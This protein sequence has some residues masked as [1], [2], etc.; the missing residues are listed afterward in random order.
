MPARSHGQSRTVLYNVWKAIRGRC[1]NPNYS[2]F[3]HYGGRGITVCEEWSNYENFHAWAMGHGWKPGLHVDRFPDQNGPY[4]PDNCRIA[5]RSQNHRNTRVNRIIE[6]FGEKK[7][8]AE[9]IDDP[10]CVVN[11]MTLFNRVHTHGWPAE[12]AITTAAMGPDR[13]ARWRQ[14]QGVV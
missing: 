3:Q 5:T 1:N 4:S 2:T 8:L 12:E 13:W 9:W 10:R 7:C 11:Y 14:M 6:A